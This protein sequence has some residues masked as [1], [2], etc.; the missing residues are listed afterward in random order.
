MQIVNNK[1]YLIL[2]YL[3][4]AESTYLCMTEKCESHYIISLC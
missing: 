1:L 3:F 4:I 2:C